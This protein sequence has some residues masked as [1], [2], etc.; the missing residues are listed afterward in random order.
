VN[1]G[2]PGIR[3]WDEIQAD[4][5]DTYETAVVRQIAKKLHLTPRQV[6]SADPT[7]EGQLTVEALVAATNFPVWLVPRHLG[8]LDN[9]EEQLE[10]RITKTVLWRTFQ[11]ALDD[12]PDEYLTLR[13]VA[14]IFKW[15]KHGKYFVFHNFLRSDLGN[16]GRWYRVGKGRELFFLEQLDDFIESIGLD[17][18]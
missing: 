11:E 8:K 6:E 14:V 5:Q 13:M 10:K 3:S 12:L 4:R 1:S 18:R 17:D 9:L 16:R 15:P 7:G 2:R